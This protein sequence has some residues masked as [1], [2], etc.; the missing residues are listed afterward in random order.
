[1]CEETVQSTCSVFIYM[2]GPQEVG[3]VLFRK[4]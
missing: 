1:V 2:K 3:F 4:N